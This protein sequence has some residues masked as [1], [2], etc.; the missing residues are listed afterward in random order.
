MG[1]YRVY[2]GWGV[3]KLGVP[4]GGSPYQGLWYFGVYTGVPLIGNLPRK[5]TQNHV[6]IRR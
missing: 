2:I 6:R 5:V 4:F 1:L 3:Q